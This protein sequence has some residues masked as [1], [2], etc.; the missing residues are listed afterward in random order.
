MNFKRKIIPTP[1]GAVYVNPEEVCFLKA[2]R[3]CTQ[4]IMKDHEEHQVMLS[5]SQA[6]ERLNC[7]YFIRTHRSYVVNMNHIYKVKGAFECLK[8][9][10]QHKIPVS[11]QRRPGVKK[12][13]NG[14]E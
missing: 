14:V 7:M 13:L 5:L 2:N 3:H 12:I 10:T 11:R 8:L 6:H 1:G 9:T 4:M